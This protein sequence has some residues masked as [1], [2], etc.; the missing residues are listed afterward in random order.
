MFNHF[1]GFTTFVVNVDR[2]VLSFRANTK[3]NIII[4]SFLDV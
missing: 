2:G 1:R 4:I 3:N